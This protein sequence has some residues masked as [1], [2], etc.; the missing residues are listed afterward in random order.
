MWNIGYGKSILSALQHKLFSSDFYIIITQ[1]V[2]RLEVLCKNLY[3]STNATERA[4]AEKALV[5]FQVNIVLPVKI[6]F[7]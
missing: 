1:E 6:I 2:C 5:G 7:A 4:D 3:E